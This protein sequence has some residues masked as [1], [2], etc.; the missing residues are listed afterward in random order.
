[1]WGINMSRSV[2]DFMFKMNLTQRR[3]DPSTNA[4]SNEPDVQEF[5]FSDDPKSMDMILMGCDG[6][7]DGTVLPEEIK[8]YN[9]NKSEK[10]QGH[11]LFDF[12]L[13]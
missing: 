4:L 11:Q 3:R 12:L 9:D 6:I 8:N 5:S 2:G 7:W 1:M 13:N 10:P